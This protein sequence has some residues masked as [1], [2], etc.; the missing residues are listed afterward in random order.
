MPGKE[1]AALWRP[2]MESPKAVVWF[3]GGFSG[4]LLE[5]SDVVG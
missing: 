1:K 3:E 4:A 5:H 2:E